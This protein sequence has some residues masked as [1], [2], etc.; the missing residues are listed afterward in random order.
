MKAS[1][2]EQSERPKQRETRQRW[3]KARKVPSMESEGQCTRGDACSFRHGENK[4]G[5]AM[6]PSSP[7][8]K[9]QTQ[10]DGKNCSK[11]KA[12]RSHQSPSRKRTRWP[13]KDYISATRTNQRWFLASSRVSKL[14][15][16]IVIANSANSAYSGTK[17]LTISPTKNKKTKDWWTR[18]S[19]LIEELEAIRLRNPW[20]RSRRNPSR[21]YGRAHNS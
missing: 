14:Q 2:Q 5:M 15:N 4:R 10:S 3:Q 6:Q 12:L 8:P 21:L 20:C 1:R 13:C 16:G 17:R 7:A 19:C 9:P 11:R 18:F